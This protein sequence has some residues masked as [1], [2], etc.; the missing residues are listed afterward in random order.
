M[1]KE[2]PAEAAALDG[3]QKAFLSALANRLLP[4]QTGEA[5]HALVY[6]LA[7]A[8]PASKP[9]RLFQAIY[10]ALLGKPKGPRA[11]AFI[12]A[13]GPERCAARFREAAA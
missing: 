5:V 10:L 2:L 12:A 6:E 13:L 1:R 4:G 8:H 11:G 3:D 9:A 7:Q